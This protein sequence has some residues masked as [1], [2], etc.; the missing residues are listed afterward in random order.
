[1]PSRAR[2]LVVLCVFLVVAIPSIP[3]P[4]PTVVAN[5]R[6]LAVS[7]ALVP[8]DA[9]S[10][11]GDSAFTS[12]NGV[13]GGQG[14]AADPYVISGWSIRVAGTGITIQN[15]RAYV[16]IRDVLLYN[17]ACGPSVWS[18]CG[19]RGILLTNVTNVRIAGVDI[20][21]VSDGI[22]MA[23]VWGVRVENSTAS[24]LASGLV[25]TGMTDGTQMWV[26]TDVT[27][28][29]NTVWVRDTTGFAVAVCASNSVIRQNVVIG[30]N[31]PVV[32]CV[33]SNVTVVRNLVV[34][35][36]YAGI[37]VHYSSDVLV[38]SNAFI[39]LSTD[40]LGFLVFDSANVTVTRN[41]FQASGPAQ[42]EMSGTQA[43]A[44]YHND[45]NGTRINASDALDLWDNG[46][47]S[48]GNYWSDYTGVD[49][50]S[51]PT[52]TT[53]T[54]PD[55][56]GDTTRP[57]DPSGSDR[58]PLI[59]PYPLAP[60]PPGALFTVSPQSGS[61]S[62]T[63]AVNASLSVDA[64]DRLSALEVRW[65][66]QD[67]GVW[68]TPWS[69]AKIAEHTYTSEGLQRIRMAIRDSS[70]LEANTTHVVLVDQTPPV[71]SASLG[72][73]LG[74]GGWYTAPVTVTLHATDALSGVS[75]LSYRIDHDPWT[76]VTADSLD[77]TLSLR[78][79]D[80]VHRV[81]YF[82][83]DA[84]GNVEALHTLY[85]SVDS[86][87]P[88]IAGPFVSGG[89]TTGKLAVNWTGTDATSGIA[90][91]TI[92]VDDGPY[93]AVRNVTRVNLTLPDGAHTVRVR[94]FDRAGN[95][96]TAGTTFTVDTNP[97]SLR[98]PYGGLPT[99]ALVIAAGALVAI[100]VWWYRRRK[101]P[102]PE[103]VPSPGNP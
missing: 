49:L 6:P 78:L 46:Y 76:N 62:T 47:P 66:W 95:T 58:Y 11:L 60:L 17:D 94:A 64:Q 102:A 31:T 100:A 28:E 86:I 81:D 22:D 82:S 51:G 89:L 1:M 56:I 50:C 53:C 29:G 15:T 88:R 43:S 99:Y 92:S 5:P 59:E 63:F 18:S 25:A 87:E 23:T 91:Y 103:D 97:F 68:D 13:T 21:G 37:D 45:F 44:V 74:Q 70:G 72:G 16:F 19:G 39:N 79:P 85:A 35:G 38:D 4:F 54:G 101:R 14:T 57:I 75:N 73:T 77:Y 33:S 10:V 30:S 20:S 65:D 42:V 84:A 90:G 27:L 26:S 9:I 24:V 32:V 8:H 98:G 61:F 83:T 67:D 69:T 12:A 40:E 71:T 48:G 34:G 36:V 3:S 7:T 41:L 2:S 55:G 96:A 52:Q 93:E 80:G